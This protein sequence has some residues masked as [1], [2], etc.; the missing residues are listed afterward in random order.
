[1]RQ[2]SLA[3]RLI[4][5][6]V[7]ASLV[8]LVAAGLVISNLLR[9]FVEESYGQTLDATML[10]LM[11]NTAYDEDPGRPVLRL[12]APDP[13]FEQPFSG[14]YW[15]ISAGED[16]L[17]RSG[18]LWSS[19]LSVDGD[20][21]IGPQGEALMLASRNFTAPGGTA[22]LRIVATAP[23]AAID[24][25]VAR[26]V[27]PL[28]IA[29][30]VLGASLALAQLLQVRVG[31]APLR[32]LGGNLG[33]I[34]TGEID[35][36]PSE[37]YRE[38]SPVIEQMNGLIVHNGETLRRAREHVGNLAHALKTPLALIETE[39]QRPAGKARDR[40]IGEASQTMNRHIA[41][42]LRRARMAAT[43]GL[44]HARTPVAA[45]VEE[46][47]PV[48]R[49]VHADRNLNISIDIPAELT[50]SGER[51]DLEEMLGTVIDNGC[52]WARSSVH[53][54]GIADADRLVITVDDDGQGMS[55][56]QLRQAGE[57]GR[58][59]DESRHG[60]GLGLS[61]AREIA[62]IYGGELAFGKSAQGGLSV[63]LTLPRA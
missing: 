32:R 4:A 43:V 48:F 2:S 10:A 41:H 25:D 23:R 6:A 56:E 35:T 37:N 47:L 34:Q 31:L 18:S 52:K 14:W 22:P 30:V 51:Q 24:A 19:D 60:T 40:S 3:L 5:A 44:M 36:L 59:F 13:R 20:G 27:T 46:L 55:E 21:A 1:M 11:A 63:R 33:R 42:H 58:R 62:T 26:V 49:G 28:V 17:F 7:V 8:A 61:I 12:N 50:F 54:H 16:V 29:L 53:V 15:T 39:L 38:L 45:V 9:N 57:R